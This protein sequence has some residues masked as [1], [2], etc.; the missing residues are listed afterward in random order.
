MY[1]NVKSYLLDV[2][3]VRCFIVWF[4]FGFFLVM[5]AYAIV[6]GYKFYL[7]KKPQ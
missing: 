2:S 5:G 6:L 7:N 3:T 4:W 1:L